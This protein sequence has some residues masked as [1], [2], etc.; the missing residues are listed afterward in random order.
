MTQPN[1]DERRRY[2]RI[3]DTVKLSYC[4]STKPG[5]CDDYCGYDLTAEQDARIQRIITEQKHENPAIIELI[6]L[7]N[8]KIDHLAHGDKS[9]QTILAHQARNVSISACGLAFTEQEAI[10]IGTQL[11]LFLVLDSNKKIELEGLVIDCIPQNNQENTKTN[12][13][14]KNLDTATL[15]KWR[16]D[17][18]H[19]SSH[20]QELLIQHIV[21]RQST[22]LA[23]QRQ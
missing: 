6:D 23:E 3:N 16:V 7:L 17:F 22:L 15:F 14:T 10:K 9:P 13:N 4:I 12:T 1:N 11:R 21:R 20:N 8:Q 5:D 18:L 19:V 2:F